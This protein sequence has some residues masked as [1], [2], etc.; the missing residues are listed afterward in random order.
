MR[1]IPAITLA[2]FSLTYALTGNADDHVNEPTEAEIQ[3]SLKAYEAADARVDPGN[4]R[5]SELDVPMSGIEVTGMVFKTITNVFDALNPATWGAV[6]IDAASRGLTG[7]SLA[8]HG[9]S[10]QA[11]A[12]VANQ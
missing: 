2:F 5:L 12:P 7:K 6:G 1:S 8:E 9:Q 11:D 4:K 10:S 3:Q